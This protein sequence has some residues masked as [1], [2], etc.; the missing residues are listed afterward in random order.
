[1]PCSL[2]SFTIDINSNQ[3]LRNVHAFNLSSIVAFWKPCHLSDP[4]SLFVSCFFVS[5]FQRDALERLLYYGQQLRDLI[6]VP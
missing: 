2:C 1:M 4:S 6:R 3:Q 5:R